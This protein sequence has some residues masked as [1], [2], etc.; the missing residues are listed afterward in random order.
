MH[1]SA[2]RM[3]VL[4]LFTCLIALNSGSLRAEEDDVLL[5]IQGYSPV[6]YFEHGRAEKG[7][8]EY[9]AT[10]NQRIYQFTS[11]EQLARFNADPR[12]FEPMFP[13][14]CPF[15]LALGR[16]ASIDPENFKIVGGNLLLFHRSEDMDGLEEWEAENND[17][18]LLERAKA[19]YTLFRF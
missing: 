4:A 19:Q 12:S 17:D 5:G 6:S 8:P 10:Y 9:T 14:H 13:N 18:E 15:N 2:I 11:A 3:F 7:S 16:Q 1:S